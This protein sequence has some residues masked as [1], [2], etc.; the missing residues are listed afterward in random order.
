M[1]RN[2]SGLVTMDN[3]GLMV[4]PNKAAERTFLQQREGVLA[5]WRCRDGDS[6]LRMA[7]ECAQSVD[8]KSCDT[9]KDSRRASTRGK[10][11]LL[12]QTA[13]KPMDN[14]TACD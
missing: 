2:E 8:P 7:G 13:D 6:T 1:N 4:A 14:L 3:V 10:V 11:I 12:Q 5:A 9:S